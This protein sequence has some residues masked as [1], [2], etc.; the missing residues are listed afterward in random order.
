MQHMDDATDD[1]LRDRARIAYSFD[2]IARATGLS[3]GFLRLEAARGRLKVTRL[4]RR[5]LVRRNALEDY[6]AAGETRDAQ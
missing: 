5:V 2:E 3:T 6:L 4:G 1:A